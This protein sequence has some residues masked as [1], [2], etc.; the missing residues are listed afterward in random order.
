MLDG[1]EV[2]QQQVLRFLALNGTQYDLNE[3]LTPVGYARRYGLRSANNVTNWM[4][5]GIIPSVDI[6]D[7]PGLNGL[8]LVRDRVY[9][10][11]NPQVS[12]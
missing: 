8:K 12:K 4:M 10:V 3:W 11:I 5:R 1:H 7:V 6:V 2:E 9:K